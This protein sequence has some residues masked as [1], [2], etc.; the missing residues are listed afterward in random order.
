M[1]TPLAIVGLA[2]SLLCGADAAS[3]Y[4]SANTID[5]HATYKRDGTRVR[6]TGP[7]GCTRGERVSIR[8]TVTQ[9]ATGARARKSWTSRCTGELQH[10][11]VRALTRRG[12]RFENG[13]GRACAVAETRSA[14]RVT[15]TRTWC[16][17]VRLLGG[18]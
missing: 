12:T 13:T 5:R 8:V 14:D 11:Q 6:T 16:E 4:I 9:A 18:F 7:I 3:A 2:A 1:R 17:R 10:W 15:D